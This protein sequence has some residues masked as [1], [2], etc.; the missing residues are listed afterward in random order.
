MPKRKAE[1]KI[2]LLEPIFNEVLV[3]NS[4]RITPFL[5]ILIAPPENVTHQKLGTIFGIFEIIDYSDD[6]SY[7]VN[8]L[9]SVIKKEYFS[10]S[11]RT[12]LESL[13]LSLHKANLALSK[14]AAHDNVNW[15]G[16]VN[17]ICGVIEKNNF[18]FSQTGNITALL[19]RSRSLT[20]ISENIIPEDKLNP[21]KTFVNLSSGKIL[22]GDKIIVTTSDIFNVFSFEEI[23]KNAL[24]FSRDEYLQFL[25]T[26][27]GNELDK[28]A[29][30]VIDI[31]EK[32]EE[33][34]ARPRC[35]KKDLNAFSQ[36]AFQK[37][38]EQEN[39]TEI[40]EEISEALKEEP[41][42][43]K[44]QGHI[45]IKAEESIE[46]PRRK[47]DGKGILPSIGIFVLGL[48]SSLGKGFLSLI[49]ILFSKIS[50]LL[51]MA[52]SWIRKKISKI[53]KKNSISANQE[54]TL[55]SDQ[56]IVQPNSLPA[57]EVPASPRLPAL[58]K[59][60]AK[61]LYNLK[62]L[63]SR[64]TYTQKIYI[65]LA[66]LLIFVV[67]YFIVKIEK[68]IQQKKE[69]AATIKMLEEQAPIVEEKTV[70]GLP[71]NIPA[72]VV[73]YSGAG[74][75]KPLVIK[76]S[77]YI[78]K[79][80]SI[81][82]LDQQKDFPYPQGFSPDNACVMSDLNMIFLVNRENKL[83]S[84]NVSSYQFEDNIFP[85]PS[86]AQTNFI[87]TY[88]T[89]LYALDSVNSKIY[90]YPRVEGGFGTPTNWLKQEYSLSNTSDMTLNDNVFII[91]N[92][93][94]KKFFKGL[95]EDWKIDETTIKVIPDRIFATSES[96]DLFVLDKTDACIF[97]IDPSGNISQQFCH[98]EIKKAQEFSIDLEHQKAVVSG[99]QDVLNFNLTSP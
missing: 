1:K 88:M 52:A 63:F 55:S 7:I 54:K 44:T 39:K 85:I 92:G 19:L 98:P 41:G 64:F 20:E 86:G 84:F 50:A 99:E 53:P 14:L 15:I 9:I 13:E 65:I 42:I 27:L 29:V 40:A 34:V 36:V 5:E 83:A 81:H 33:E 21:L 45:Y 48:L 68:D 10:S 72:P 23:K 75:I 60:L 18:H 76:G 80:D 46:K 89:Y 57:K 28:S 24:R 77:T 16:K 94:T 82:D 97:K 70:Q 87:G 96:T 74:I 43:A 90:R 8:Y 11:K 95:A 58:F 32:L 51:M 22:S 78:I 66:A 49:K 61:K 73:V 6:S 91:D 31:Q 35:Q 56:E 59:P 3:S 12:S 30:L 26:A 25:R 47:S 69:R 93:Q 2:A 38:R 37:E 4:K 62:S 71:A 67:P 17:A 79:N